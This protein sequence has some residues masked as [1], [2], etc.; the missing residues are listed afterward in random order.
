MGSI[1]LGAKISL[2]ALLFV[3]PTLFYPASHLSLN[4]PL[5]YAHAVYP[6]HFLI[7]RTFPDAP[8][9]H[10]ACILTTCTSLTSIPS[11]Y[12]PH[13]HTF[14]A[15]PS[16]PLILLTICTLPSPPLILL[17]ICILPSPPILFLTIYVSPSPPLIYRIIY[18][19]LSRLT[20]IQLLLFEPQLHSLPLMRDRLRSR[21]AK[22]P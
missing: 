14:Y 12:F 7:L 1:E 20:P 3:Y 21:C 4:Y 8:S 19:L 6:Q 16:P 18:V 17:T 11:T 13:F 15:L 9:L 2:K 22:R 10:A 5:S